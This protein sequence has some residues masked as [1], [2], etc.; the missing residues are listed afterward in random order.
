MTQFDKQK[1]TEVILYILNKTKGLDYY[2]VFKIIYFANIAHLAKYGFSMVSDEFCALPDGPVPSILYNCIKDDVHCDKELKNMLDKT[3]AKGTDD[4]YYMLE[5][6]RDAD[7]DYLSK[8]DIE[9]LDQSI[10]EN[11]NLPYGELRAKSHGEEWSRAYNQQGR[12]VM[13]IVGMAKDGMA[14]ED[15]IEYIKENLAVEAALA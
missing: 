6:K 15:M 9:A 10:E 3:V 5:A 11:R 13:D 7:L 14:S 4:A 2:H 1:L 12:K 8:A